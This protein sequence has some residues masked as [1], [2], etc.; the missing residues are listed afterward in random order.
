M[1]LASLQAPIRKQM[2]GAFD[3]DAVERI[4]NGV[5]AR[6]RAIARARARAWALGVAAT[7]LLVFGVAWTRMRSVEP[8]PLALSDGAAIVALHGGRTYTLSDGS[9]IE[10]AD[11][12]TLATTTSSAHAFDATLRDGRAIF[13]VVPGGPRRWTID[14]GLASVE[15]VGTRFVVD[16]RADRVSVSVERGHVR[17]RTA[18]GVKDLYAGE[19]TEVTAAAPKPAP[20]AEPDVPTF[21]LHDLPSAAPAPSAAPT[22]WRDRARAGDNGGAYAA[23]GRDGVAAAA[24][25]ASVDDLF[26]LADVAR[27]SG[28]PADAVAPLERILADHANDAR[29]GLAAFTLGR[30]ELDTLGHPARAARAFERAI[31]L[32][33]LVEDAYARLVE[34]RAKA[35]DRAGAQAA[36]DAYVRA[37]PNGGRSRAMR[38]WLDDDAQP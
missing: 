38:R 28:H 34:A 30:L 7:L 29:A 10:L 18:T 5:G 15:V 24:A 17:V 8:G 14:A 6:R 11:D 27:L 25:S 3:E 4:W 13:D 31:A 22:A 23:L 9:R 21:D 12:A 37:F 35:G 33:T 16:A 2:P 19:A 1:R 20:S 26:A 36:F 32:G